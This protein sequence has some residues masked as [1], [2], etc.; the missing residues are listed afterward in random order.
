MPLRKSHR[1]SDTPLFN[2]SPKDGLYAQLLSSLTG[3]DDFPSDEEERSYYQSKNQAQWCQC[4][5]DPTAPWPIQRKQAWT[6]HELFP[7]EEYWRHVQVLWEAGTVD[8]S[9]NNDL[10]WLLPPEEEAVKV[11]W[12]AWRKGLMEQYHLP[13]GSNPESSV[14]QS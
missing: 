6:A 9:E 3:V 8:S 11:E 10:R 1:R 4:T 7:W 12:Q 5:P 13:P 2:G 14:H